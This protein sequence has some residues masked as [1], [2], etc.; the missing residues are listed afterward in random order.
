MAIEGSQHGYSLKDSS[1]VVNYVEDG[2]ERTMAVDVIVVDGL[3]DFAATEA[4]IRSAVYGDEAPAAIVP[5]S[6]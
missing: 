3:V 2:Q 4:A 5:P 6:D 1:V